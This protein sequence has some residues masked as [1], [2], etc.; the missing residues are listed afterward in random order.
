MF[1]SNQIFEISGS[2][3]Q[4]EDAIRF[5]LKHYGTPNEKGLFYQV[6]ED[7]KYCLG[8]SS[9]E[10]YWKKFPFDFNPHIVSEIIEQH[11]KKAMD[12]MKSDYEWADGS[13][14]RG[15]L[16]KAIP[17]MF[18]DEYKGIK[19]PFYGIISIEPFENFYAK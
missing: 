13:T 4:L 18:S 10:N 17:D 5:A 3:E 6:T 16:M 2:L 11:I 7:G 12:N 19:K 8:W 9:D 1:S 15:F 14:G